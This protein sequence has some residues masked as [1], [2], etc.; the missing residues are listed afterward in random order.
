[1]KASVICGVDPISEMLQ[2]IFARCYFHHPSDK[3]H[4]G[5]LSLYR[6]SWR[7]L[8]HA[9]LLDNV[10]SDYLWARAVV[11]T[12]ATAATVGLAFQTPVA[13][14]ADILINGNTPSVM[15]LMGGTLVT[16][17]FFGVNVTPLT[18]CAGK[19]EGGTLEP[20]GLEMP[21]DHQKPADHDLRTASFN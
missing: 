10:L 12:T 14:V 18:S 1:M 9:G 17:G 5:I 15:L 8:I 11:L 6:S 16:L 3:I 19:L 4:A 20:G 7:F 21:S 13:I 2:N